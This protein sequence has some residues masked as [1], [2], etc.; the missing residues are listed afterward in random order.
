MKASINYVGRTS[1]EVGVRVEAEDLM[2]GRRRHTNSCYLTFVAV[3]RN[4][5]PIDVPAI[6]PEDGRTRY[7]GTPPRS[8]EG[9]GDWKSAK[10][11]DLAR[12]KPRVSF[13]MQLF[14]VE[15]ANRTL[16]LVRQIVEDVVAQHRRWRET[17]LELDLVASSVPR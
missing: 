1:M 4:G 6:V 12:A 17:I 9:A 13:G 8:S 7:A 14:T 10:P 11:S 15:Q 5:R 2:T 16:P 3:D